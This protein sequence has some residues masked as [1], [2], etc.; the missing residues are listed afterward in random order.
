MFFYDTNGELSSMWLNDSVYYYF[1]KNAQGDVVSVITSG[2]RVQIQYKY[3]AW[4]NPISITS[5]GDSDASSSFYAT[6]LSFMYRGYY[7]DAETGFYYLNSRYYDPVTGRFINADTYMDT[8]SGTP[9]STN[10]YAYCENNPV[11]FTDPNGEWATNEH[12][13]ISRKAGFKTTVQN[14][15]TNPDKFFESDDNYSAPFHSRSNGYK[16]AAYLYNKAMEVKRKKKH[17]NFTYSEDNGT[18]Y[19]DPKYLGYIDKNTKKREIT[20]IEKARDLLKKLNIKDD[21]TKT[22]YF[23]QYK[24]L[25]GLALHTWQDYYAHM[26]EIEVYD[27]KNKK[28]LTDSNGASLNCTEFSNTYLKDTY[29]F[30]DNSEILKWRYKRACE[31]TKEVYDNS[32]KKRIIVD[33]ELIQQKK[34]FK[35]DFTYS[36]RKYKIKYKKSYIK[37]TWGK[38]NEKIM[39][40]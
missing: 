24:I 29:A 8:G 26:M 14:W 35:K 1:V 25:M 11:M 16:I 19:L 7:Y 13:N 23:Y 10:V 6:V 33:I 5:L 30:E 4:G 15:S 9:L 12:A 39:F 2:G 20:N 28:W 17:I 36:S 22:D 3:D 32:N 37:I 38:K 40:S 27:Y 21:G 31:I 34:S 18:K